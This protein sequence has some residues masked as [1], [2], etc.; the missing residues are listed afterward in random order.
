MKG[1]MRWVL[2]IGGG[3]FAAALM[4]AGL[5]AYLVTRLDVR[6]EVER[7]VE[8]ATG[9]DLVINGN[10]GVSY[11]PVLGLRAEDATLSNVEGGRA[12]AFITADEIDIG[13]EIGPLFERQVVVRRLVFQRPQI[14]LEVNAEGEPNW[15]LE[16]RRAPPGTPTPPP[17]SGDPGIDIARAN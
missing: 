6:G 14:N 11:W 9:R 12:P 3:L 1:W 13:V 4:G 17:T 2:L 5:L 16:P 15:V 10:V 8:S 7:V